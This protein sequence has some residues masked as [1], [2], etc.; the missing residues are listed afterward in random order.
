MLGHGCALFLK[1]RMM[2]TAD[3]YSTYI[4][5]SCGLFA[6]RM[7]K[8]DNKPYVTHKDIYYCPACNNKTKIAKI[9]IPYAFKLLL[10]EMMSMNI[11]P[12]MR[13][14]KNQLED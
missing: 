6:Q 13:I 8:R 2:D 9:R 14:K 10:Q 4:C 11:A 1:E 5:M 12:R 3:A 7:L